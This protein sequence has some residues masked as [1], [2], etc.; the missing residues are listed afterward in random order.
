MLGSSIT[1]DGTEGT[2]TVT[3]SQEGDNNY[4]S[5]TESISFNVTLPLSVEKLTDMVKIYPNP[6][7]EHLYVETKHPLSI[8][9]FTLEGRLEKTVSENG[10]I[11]VSDLAAGTYILEIIIEDERFFERIIKAN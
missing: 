2:V 3:V 4:H 1:L 5:A 9:F 6:V 11:D 10:R 7:V 8:K